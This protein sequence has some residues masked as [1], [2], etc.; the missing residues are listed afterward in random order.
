MGLKAS[1]L[2]P[3][4]LKLFSFATIQEQKET[5]DQIHTKLLSLKYQLTDLNNNEET[6]RNLVTTN[7]DSQDSLSAELWGLCSIPDQDITEDEF[8]C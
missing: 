3:R 5:E 6:E 7:E 8:T 1:F 2:D 4:M